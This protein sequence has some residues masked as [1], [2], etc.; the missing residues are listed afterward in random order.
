MTLPFEHRL[1]CSRSLSMQSVFW[2][3]MSPDLKV[4]F[5]QLNIG[6]S[7]NAAGLCVGCLIFIPFARKYGR[8]T[9]YI[10]STATMAACAWW[11]ARME[12][13]TEVYLTNVIFGLAG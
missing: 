9:P 5:N 10:L 13:L 4:T 7:C 6:L 2:P 3:Q 12:T 8:R 11:S 1:R